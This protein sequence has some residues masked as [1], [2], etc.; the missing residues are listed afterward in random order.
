VIGRHWNRCWRSIERSGST[1][2]ATGGNIEVKEDVILNDGRPGADDDSRSKTTE[3]EWIAGK[4][5]RAG[6]GVVERNPIQIEAIAG[7]SRHDVVV[8]RVRQT[9]AGRKCH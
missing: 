3:A 4:R 2:E 8:C 5:D 7:V 1:R 6:S 9:T